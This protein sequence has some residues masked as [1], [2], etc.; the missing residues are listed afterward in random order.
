VID[1]VRAAEFIRDL[2]HAIENPQPHLSPA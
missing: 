2:V 1:G